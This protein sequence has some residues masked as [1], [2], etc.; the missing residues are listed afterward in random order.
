MKT[1]RMIPFGLML[2]LLA[3]CAGKEEAVSISVPDETSVQAER[4]PVPEPELEAPGQPYWVL[5]ECSYDGGTAVVY[6]VQHPD[7]YNKRF[8][9][10]SVFYALRWQIF[11]VQ[12]RKNG[13]GDSGWSNSFAI[14]GLPLSGLEAREGLLTFSV[15]MPAEYSGE[16]LRRKFTLVLDDEKLPILGE[17]PNEWTCGRPAASFS[18]AC[19]SPRILL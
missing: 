5:G 6:E 12:G 17:N 13:A 9:S 7:S 8:S 15:Q 4:E 2:L 3:G 10:D 14:H 1:F 18:R 11:D 16:P 19:I